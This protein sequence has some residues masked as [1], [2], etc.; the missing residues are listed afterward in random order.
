MKETSDLAEQN[1]LL[2]KKLE[3]EHVTRLK[4][5]KQ[6]DLYSTQLGHVTAERVALQEDVVSGKHPHVQ[7][8]QKRISELEGHARHKESLT[9]I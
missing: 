3:E 8:L 9:L 6:A 4:I 5:E 1:E 2:K 7:E